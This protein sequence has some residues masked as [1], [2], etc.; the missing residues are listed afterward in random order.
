MLISVPVVLYSSREEEKVKE[1]KDDDNKT[2]GREV[3]SP[4]WHITLKERLKVGPDKVSLCK[5]AKGDF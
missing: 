5:K 3:R 1:I 2:T 4:F